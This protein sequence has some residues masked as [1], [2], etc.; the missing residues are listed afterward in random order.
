[1]K[2]DLKAQADLSLHLPHMS[3]GIESKFAEVG[4][5]SAVFVDVQTNLSLYQT[6]MSVSI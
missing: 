3:E 1:M 5:R 6:H 4:L 2:T